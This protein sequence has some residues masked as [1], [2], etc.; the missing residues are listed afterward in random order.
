ML[1][2]L[3]PNADSG[4]GTTGSGGTSLLAS[5]FSSSTAPSSSV[6]HST[7]TFSDFIGS[8]NRSESTSLCLS[9]VA[10][11]PN[12][13]LFSSPP[14]QQQFSPSPHLSATA[15]LQKAAQM[16]A[17]TSTSS[18][19]LRGFGL[20]PSSSSAARQEEEDGSLQWDGHGQYQNLDP[21][22][23]GLGLG[24]DTGNLMLGSSSSS[25]FFGPKLA[26]LDLLGLGIG[27]GGSTTGGLSALITSMAGGGL[28]VG[29]GAS[30]GS[31]PSWEGSDRKPAIL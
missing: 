21:P 7:A 2:Y 14:Q 31:A 23:L 12:S 24:Y 9:T 18:S 27:P 3:P 13:P 26:T 6:G 30:S 17:A 1:Q 29:P 28:D 22:V 16:G 20:A 25:A 19:F 5:L 10:P 15:L 4:S 11:N 8:M